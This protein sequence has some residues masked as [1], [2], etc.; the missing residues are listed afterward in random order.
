MRFAT[1]TLLCLCLLLSVSY[2][3][4][5][6]IVKIEVTKTELYNNRKQFG[7]AGEY[8][9]IF[10]KA[11]GEVDPNDS[12]NSIIQDIQLAP[13]NAAGKVEYVSD[14]ILLRPKDISKSNGILFLSLPNRGNVFPADTALLFME[15]VAG[16][17]I[18]RQ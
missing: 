13:R 7:D 10:G 8:I 3:S 9:R 17:C 18:T 5:G 2:F 4:V 11:Y 14:F 12:L 1:K 16:R 6:E 15:R